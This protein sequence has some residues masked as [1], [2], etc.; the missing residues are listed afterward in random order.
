MRGFVDRFIMLRKIKK[1]Y[2]DYSIIAEM[3]T[4]FG[5]EYNS[6][7]LFSLGIKLSIVNYVLLDEKL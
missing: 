1:R 6:E 4:D 3:A 5:R 2:P 7:N